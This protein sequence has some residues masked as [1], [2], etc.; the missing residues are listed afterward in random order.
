MSTKELEIL[1]KQ[2]EHERLEF[3]LKANFPEKIVKELVAFANTKGGTLLVG[4]NDDRSI[5]GLKFAGEDFFVLQQA[6]DKLIRPELSYETEFVHLSDKKSVL[7]FRV[8]EG[9]RKPYFVKDNESEG[10]ICYVRVA[11]MSVKASKEMREIL[12]RSRNQ[13]DIRFHFGEKEKWLLSYLAENV[14]IS[15]EQFAREYKISRYMASKTLVILTLGNVLKILPSD[16]G[17][18]FLVREP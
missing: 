1:V 10:A 2:G 11:D 18:L 9:E 12:R 16:K 5:P 17:D 15:V 3:K 8:K 4:V 14:S 7:V 13:K 6:I